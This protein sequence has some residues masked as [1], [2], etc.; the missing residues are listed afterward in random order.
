[1]DAVAKLL[2]T[3]KAA[4]R[5]FLAVAKAY[6]NIYSRMKLA[7]L[8]KFSLSM[9]NGSRRLAGPT[10]KQERTKDCNVATADPRLHAVVSELCTVR[11]SKYGRAK[12]GTKSGSITEL[13]TNKYESDKLRKTERRLAK[14]EEDK[15]K[16]AK[17][18]LERIAFSIVRMTYAIRMG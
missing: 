1:M 2:P 16:M 15:A 7:N 14:A 18:H 9:C 11:R 5:P 3:N 17:K 12:T 13:L 6:L 4:E 8:A 10:G